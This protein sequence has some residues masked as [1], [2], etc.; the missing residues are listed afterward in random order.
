MYT[1]TWLIVTFIMYSYNKKNTSRV[2]NG[3]TDVK[4]VTLWRIA[5]ALNIKPSKFFKILEI[6]LGKDFQFYET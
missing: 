2:E 4:V 1:I 5:E 3:T 6:K